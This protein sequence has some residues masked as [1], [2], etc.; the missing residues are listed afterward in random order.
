MYLSPFWEKKKKKKCPQM[1]ELLTCEM[2]EKFSCVSPWKKFDHCICFMHMKA[3][4]FH[5]FVSC[6]YDNVP[7]TYS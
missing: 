3:Q 2:Y 5:V 1:I 6:L 7:L 4:M